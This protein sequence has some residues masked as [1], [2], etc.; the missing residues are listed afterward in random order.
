MFGKKRRQLGRGPASVLL[1]LA[2]RDGRTRHAPRQLDPREPERPGF[3]F[4]CAS[5]AGYG[6]APAMARRCF[7][8]LDEEGITATVSVL[9]VLSD[10]DN[11]AT[12]GA[13]WPVAGR[14]L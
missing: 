2:Q 10:T 9:R 3:T 13:V 11:V 14:V 8:R 5:R 7:E 6:V 12:Q 1:D 4:R